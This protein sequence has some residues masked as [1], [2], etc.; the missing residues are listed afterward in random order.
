MGHL[1]GAFSLGLDVYFDKINV[2]LE[3]A[4]TEVNTVRN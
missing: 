2:F 3:E 1:K 4:A